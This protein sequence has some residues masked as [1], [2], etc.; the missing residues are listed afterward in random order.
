MAYRKVVD[1]SSEDYALWLHQKATRVF[2]PVFTPLHDWLRMRSR[3]YNWWHTRTFSSTLNAALL[4]L[5]VIAIGNVT[6]KTLVVAEASHGCVDTVSIT[7]NTT[8]STDQCHGDVTVSNSATLT[9]NGGVTVDVTSLTLGNGVTNGFITAKGDTLNGVGVVIN[10]DSSVEVKVGSSISANGQGYIGGRSGDISGKGPGG[11]STSLN[12]TTAGGGG[13]GGGGANGDTTNN[14]FG[15][16]AYGSLDSPADLGSGGGY[17]LG[18]CGNNGGDGGGA[19]KINAQSATVTVNGTITANGTGGGAGCCAYAGGGSGGSIWII[20]DSLVGSGTVS[21]NGGAGGSGGAGEGNNGGAGGGGRVQ[22]SFNDNSSTITKSAFDGGNNGQNR[23]GAAGTVSTSAELIIANNTSPTITPSVS[24]ALSGT[25]NYSSTTFKNY[26]DVTMA[27]GASYSGGTTIIQNNAKLTLLA[28]STVW[29]GGTLTIDTGTNTLNIPKSISSEPEFGPITIGSGTLQHDS[30]SSSHL[31]SLILNSTGD[32]SVTGTINTNTKGYSGGVTGDVNGKGPGGGDG[33]TTSKHAGGGAYGGTGGS[34]GGTGIQTEVGGTA[35]GSI[36]QPVDLG[37]GGGYSLGSSGNN[38][39]AGGG[40]VKLSTSA[41]LSITGTISANG[42]AGGAACCI[43]G[44]GGSGGSVWLSASTLSGNGTVTANG[45]NP[46]GDGST[47]AGGGAGG[48]VKFSYTTDNSTVTKQAFGAHGTPSAAV[49]GGSGTILNNSGLVVANNTAKTT[50]P[51]ATPLVASSYTFDSLS[52]KDYSN[53]TI[54]NSTTLSGGS[55][56]VQNSST[57]TLLGN[58]SVWTG[59]ALST[60]TG[61][62]LINIPPGIITKPLFS[63]FTHSSGTLSHSDNTSADLYHLIISVTG[64]TVIDSTI[65]VSSKGYTGGVNSTTGNGPGA[66]VGHAVGGGAGHGGTGGTGSSGSGG[67]GGPSYGL[68]YEPVT[69]GSGGGGGG[70][71]S[72]GDGGGALQISSGGTLTINS[73]VTANGG[74]GYAGCCS[75]GGGGSGGSIFLAADT[76]AGSGNL[77][78]AG[79]AGGGGAGGGGCGAGGR[80]SRHYSNSSYSGTISVLKGSGSCSDGQNGTNQTVGTVTDLVVSGVPSPVNAGNSNSITVEA[81]DVSN[82]RN[83]SYTK[84]ITFTSSDGQADLPGNYA[85]TTANAG[86]ATISGV[87]LK[88]AGTQSVT[89]DQS[90][91]GTVDG[92]Q[93]NIVV[94]PGSATSLTVSGVTDPVTAGVTTSPVVIAKDAYNNT[95]TGYTGTITFTSTDAQAT[96]PSNYTFVGGDAGTKT[97]TNGVTLKIAGEQTLTTTDTVSGS[98]TGSQTAITVNAAAIDALLLAGIT[99]PTVAGTSH[100]PT[101]TAKDAYSN[102]VTSYS[103]TVAFSSSDTAADLPTNYTF[104]GSDNGVKTFT[105]GLKFKT[106]GSQS[107]TVTDGTKSGNAN[108]I[109]VTAGIVSTL[110][111]SNVTSPVTAGTNNSATVTAQDEF[112]NTVTG[113]TGTIRLT[114]SDS[115]ATLPANYT[116]VAGDSGIH[117]FSN[118]VVFNTAGT[119]SLTATDTNTTSINGSL[120][121][122]LVTAKP[123]QTT[124]PS[125]SPPTPPGDEPAPTIPSLT[126]VFIEPSTGTFTGTIEQLVNGV[127][128]DVVIVGTIKGKTLSG[129]VSGTYG[130]DP[131]S[132]SISGTLKGKSIDSALV[133]LVGTVN[134]QVNLSVIVSGVIN[135]PTQPVAEQPCKIRGALEMTIDGKKFTGEVQLTVASDGTVTGG[136]KGF[137]DDKRVFGRFTA[138]SIQGEIVAGQV[139]LTETGKNET[140]SGDIVGT[141]DDGEI[142][143]SNIQHCNF[144]ADV[145]V[146][147]DGDGDSDGAGTGSV[148]VDQPAVGSD[149]I[150]GGVQAVIEGDVSNVD[151]IMNGTF[152]TLVANIVVKPSGLSMTTVEQ[153]EL[154][155]GALAVVSGVA[156]LPTLPGLQ[157]LIITS[158]TRGVSF[159]QWF[160]FGYVPRRKRKFWGVIRDKS[161]HVPVVAALARL[162]DYRTGNELKNMRTDH[163]GRYGFLIEGSGEY[164]VRVSDPMYANYKSNAIIIRNLT[165]PIITGDIGLD[166]IAQQ[167]AKL[168]ARTQLYLKIIWFLNIIHWPLLIAGTILSAWLVYEYPTALRILALGL[169]S[170]L[171][172]SKLVGYRRERHFGQVTDGAG[173][174]LSRAVIQLT[175]SRNDVTSHVQSTVTDKLGRFVLLVKPGAYEIIVAKEGFRIRRG[176]IIADEVN[177]VIKLEPDTD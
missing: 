97:F 124:P 177:I 39:G 158:S 74:G 52:I 69:L 45:G 142:V 15:G 130:S 89:A 57:V 41:N 33:S 99:A 122:I 91:D 150:S 71:G 162:F 133:T 125:S 170:S 87:V 156:L 63:S 143:I 139:T 147:T 129:T 64:N 168:V 106:A 44:G 17:A 36:T 119:Q 120:A 138:T 88:T 59:T 144:T 167:H 94:N 105:N 29:S 2:F 96:L 104:T 16:S 23:R 171:W 30:H 66:G 123:N 61:T 58:N 85:F 19:V 164:Q 137:L 141:V 47:A 22:I 161:T 136:A 176:D 60:Q 151:M 28:D 83:Y 62:N 21:A 78:S 70:S 9:I 116:F 115:A 35:F 95:A 148:V 174:P 102:I 114:S 26:V 5:T 56:T 101:V 20:A 128:L 155:S 118:N 65:D 145:D 49:R 12:V 14:N 13:Y 160:F 77:T 84:T 127:L 154:I 4:V 153:N 73:A 3:L 31:Y 76:I 11:A 27:S 43:Y 113:Y 79:G 175:S 40:A 24:T 173:N 163:T 135:S 108:G 32:I 152:E 93:A 169:Y 50:V 90:D 92:S 109:V 53:L 82:N 146:D 54:S 25:L 18:C 166:P 72:G 38:G 86:Q 131:V 134:P 6:T 68:G 51:A 112:N 159:F 42:G 157:S 10:A 7:S 34:G 121:G 117:I 103:G 107:V 149:D 98:I 48:R 165:E 132:G 110:K 75:Y 46:G 55:T 80:I 8:W 37:S 81:R 111:V 1:L 172:I 67:A 126:V 140:L 100:S